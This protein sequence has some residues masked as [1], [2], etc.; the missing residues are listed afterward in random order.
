MLRFLLLRPIAVIMVL[1]AAL[2]LSLLAFFKLPVSLLPD[3]DVP[4]I[5]ISV[6][7]PNSPPE[8]IEQ[9][10]LKP[11]RESMLTL[12]GLKSAES[13]ARQES[14]TVSLSLEYGTDI[15]LAYIEANEKIDR[16]TSALPRTLDRPQV[17]KTNTSDIPVIRIQVI[18]QR[19]EKKIRLL[20]YSLLE[21]LNILN[22]RQCSLMGAFK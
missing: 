5:T 3:I 14:G 9:N 21:K 19:Q 10:I 18:P 16:L 22:R 17:V 12:N 7:Y 13:I 6:Q 8:E 20:I 11:I 15:N 2:A 4:E 1:I